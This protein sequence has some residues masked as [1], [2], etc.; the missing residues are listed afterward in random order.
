MSGRLAIAI[1]LGG[2]QLRAALVDGAKVLRRAAEPTDAVGGPD[3]VLDQMRRLIAGVEGD[4]DHA[5]VAG[6]GISAP[7]PLNGETGTILHIP[8]LPGWDDYPLRDRLRHATGRA[9]VLENDG[10][11]AAVGEWRHGA[12]QGLDHLVYVTVSTGIGGGVIAD[13]RVLHG[14]RGM[15]GHVGHFT[16]TP[17]GPRCPCGVIGCFEAHASGTA[18]GKRARAA[19][20]AHP[21][22]AL[23][24]L[25]REGHVDARHV[26]AAAREGDAVARALIDEEAWLLGRGFASLVHLYSPERV[27]MGGGVV[28]GFDLME[29]RIYRVMRENLMPAFRDVVVVPAGLGENAGL[30]G[31]AALILDQAL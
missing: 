19:A 12:G 4:A 1:D 20:I 28:S 31:A 30:V 15:A 8:T 23:G 3:A 25:A 26:V 10:I 24:A 21:E 18:L 13:G 22:S 14:R 29:A 11:S 27:I 17:D 7:G 5:Q 2:T 6:I 9:V 16:M